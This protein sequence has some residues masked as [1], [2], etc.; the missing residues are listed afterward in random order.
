MYLPSARNYVMS[1]TGKH[2][3]NVCSSRLQ[4]FPFKD[5]V[6]FIPS[7]CIAIVILQD[8]PDNISVNATLNC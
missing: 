2:M 6:D 7:E 3:S 4:V 8:L 1:P 5:N